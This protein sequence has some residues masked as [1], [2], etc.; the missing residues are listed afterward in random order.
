MTGT[1][2]LSIEQNWPAWQT[3]IK[4]NKQMKWRRWGMNL[5][6]HLMSMLK[7]SSLGS[8]D[9]VS[10]YRWP[11]L[12]WVIRSPGR[13]PALTRWSS[14]LLLWVLAIRSN[15]SSVWGEARRPAS[16]N[17]TRKEA[18]RTVMISDSLHFTMWD[19]GGNIEQ[20]TKRVGWARAGL[21]T[22]NPR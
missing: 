21:V 14:S 22:G 19:E 9:S 2:Y 5:T 8:W 7:K 11:M 20:L 4:I 3:V 16:G 12:F 6:W 1:S 18:F 10:L 13:F 17:S 15:S